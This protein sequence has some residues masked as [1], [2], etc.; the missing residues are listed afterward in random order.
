MV[1]LWRFNKVSGLWVME[2]ACDT[3]TAEAWLALYQDDA[4]NEAFMLSVYKP[5]HKPE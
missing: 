1:T 3:V 4:P 2:R 5:K